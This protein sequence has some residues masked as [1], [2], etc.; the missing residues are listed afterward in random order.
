MGRRVTTTGT[1]VRWDHQRVGGLTAHNKQRSLP[2]VRFTTEDGRQVEAMPRAAVDLGIYR[3][4][5]SAEVTYDVDDPQDVDVRLGG[6][7][8]NPVLLMVGAAVV[9]LLFLFVVLPMIFSRLG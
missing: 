1:V 2:V 4:G 5:Q 9:A 7:G 8:R 3:T 6:A